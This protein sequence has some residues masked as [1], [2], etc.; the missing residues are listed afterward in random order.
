MN[1]GKVLKAINQPVT[2]SEIA[3]Q[4]GLLE[5]Q[6]RSALKRISL[7]FGGYRKM[8]YGS[9]IHFY[10]PRHT[11]KVKTTFIWQEVLD[12]I[13]TDEWWSALEISAYMEVSYERAKN[14]IHYIRNR[15]YAKIEGRFNKHGKIEYKVIRE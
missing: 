11:Q 8:G 3:E 10:A 1:I 2:V 12:L 15:G 5:H 6:V 13:D 7:D 4:T 14:L 9:N